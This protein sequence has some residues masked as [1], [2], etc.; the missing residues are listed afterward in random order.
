M[1]SL[2]GL[3]AGQWF[4]LLKDNHFR[5]NPFKIPLV[6]LVSINSLRNSYFA[7]QEIKKYQE[8]VSRTKITDSP[9]FILGHWRSGTTLLFRLLSGDPQFAYP[10]VI[11]ILN[12]YT[13]LVLQKHAQPATFDRN[14]WKRPM[15]NVEISFN[16]PAEE[17]FAISMLSLR[18]PI[19][20]W[21]FPQNTKYYDQFLSFKEASAEDRRQWKEAYSY[22]LQK[23]TFRYKKRLLLKSPPN[24]ARIRLLLELYPNAKF[25]HIHRHP[26]KVFQSTLHMYQTS[27]YRFNLQRKP[28]IQDIVEIIIRR[29]KL[30]YQAFW[31]D[32]PFIPKGNF[33]DIAF[34][35]LVK[36]FEGTIKTIYQKINLAGFDIYQPILKQKI[37][38]LQ[39]YTR[40]QYPDVTEAQ[41]QRIWY[42]WRKYYELWGYS[43]GKPPFRK[44]AEDVSKQKFHY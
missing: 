35:E 30:M 2:Q 33:V 20:S 9:V 42:T 23:L 16:S 39:G 24:T 37:A 38:K 4:K 44:H 8:E 10:H 14:T 1:E 32:L 5:L 15:D 40:N 21:T 6:L 18:S 22:F 11:E 17:E 7:K 27:A 34:E 3:T 19:L 13:F 43:L 25:I 36:D 26:I 29:Y 41:L 31:E 12:P 28:S